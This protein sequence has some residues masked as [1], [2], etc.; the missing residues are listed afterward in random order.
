[1]RVLS[2]FGAA[3]AS[4]TAVIMD[5]SAA[6]HALLIKGELL[7]GSV[8]ADIVKHNAQAYLEVCLSIIPTRFL[9]II[10]YMNVFIDYEGM[11]HVGAAWRHEPP[12]VGDAAQQI[13]A[14]RGAVPSDGQDLLGF[15][16]ATAAGHEHNVLGG[17]GH[18]LGSPS[19]YSQ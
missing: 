2:P 11:G 5:L 6:Q 8:P 9:L 14:R 13:L 1:M 7:N 10:Y 19:F 18:A 4:I 12:L 15:H 16:R 17:A 3:T